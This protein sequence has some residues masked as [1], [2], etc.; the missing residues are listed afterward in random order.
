[1][2]AGSQMRIC[3]LAAASALIAALTMPALAGDDNSA[4]GAAPEAVTVTAVFGRYGFSSV[5]NVTASSCSVEMYL[6]QK[7]LLEHFD[8]LQKIGLMNQDISQT[9]INTEPNLVSMGFA[10]QMLPVATKEAYDNHKDAD[11][12][13]FKQWLTIVDD[14]GNNKKI[15]MLTYHFTRAIYEK[16]NWDQF[17]PRNMMKVALGFQ[18][19]PGFEASIISEQQN[20]N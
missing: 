13:E 12:C 4:E 17:P 7:T 19:D 9:T 10:F 6:D 1:M 18:F 14:Y 16:I 15:L 11:H 8:E 5:P 2:G 20:A 3:L